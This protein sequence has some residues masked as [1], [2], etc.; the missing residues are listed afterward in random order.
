MKKI[1]LIIGTGILAYEIYDR[2]KRNNE[3]RALAD[4]EV[5][6]EYL[7]QELAIARRN[8]YEDGER[9]RKFKR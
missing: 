4:A 5:E 9:R 7:E 8:Q 1:K 3:K 2:V 6:I